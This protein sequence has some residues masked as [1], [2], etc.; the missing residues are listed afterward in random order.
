[1]AEVGKVVGAINVDH[2]KFTILRRKTVFFE[3]F[4]Q[5]KIIGFNIIR[6]LA[7]DD[8]R[9]LHIGFVTGSG[10]NAPSV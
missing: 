10:A 8:E 5:H 3:P 9:A 4:I 2:V 1:M 7:P 6:H